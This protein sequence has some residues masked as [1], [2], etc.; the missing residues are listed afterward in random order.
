LSTPDFK[1]DW[2]SVTFQNARVGF[3]TLLKQKR[4]KYGIYTATVSSTITQSHRADSYEQLSEPNS[5]G[6]Y[7]DP[8]DG[9][10]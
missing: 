8:P 5:D 7:Y 4:Q 2:S 9:R 1:Q 3:E 10:P 6:L